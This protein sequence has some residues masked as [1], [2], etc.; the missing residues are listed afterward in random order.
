MP[1]W[2][3]W[4]KAFPQNP[5]NQPTNQPKKAVSMKFVAFDIC[6]YITLFY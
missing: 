1:A 6:I 3:T 5:T 2:A 4:Q